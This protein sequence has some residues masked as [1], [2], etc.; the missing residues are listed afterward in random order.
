MQDY[1]VFPQ[2][3]YI[4]H[5]HKHLTNKWKWTLNHNIVQDSPR[6]CKYKERILGMFS[7]KYK[8]LS[9][10]DYLKALFFLIKLTYSFPIS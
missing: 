6:D 3:L 4:E 8:L 1:Y 5:L 9:I 2:Y 10:W 7:Y